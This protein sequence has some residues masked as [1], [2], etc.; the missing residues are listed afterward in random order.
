MQTKE[1]YSICPTA[2]ALAFIVCIMI[3][4]YSSAPGEAAEKAR[5][6]TKKKAG[7]IA[8]GPF[9][10]DPILIS[11]DRMEG[12]LKK[13]T[14]TYQGRVVVI[15]GEMTMKSRVL[16]GYY[17]SELNEIKKVVANGK[18]HVTQE[19]R[20]ATGAKAVFDVKAQTITLTGNPVLREGR[21]QI[22]GSRFI[23]FVDQNRFKVEGPVKSTLIPDELMEQKK[24]KKELGK[25]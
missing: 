4:V 18:V 22:S 3:A 8:T 1:N 11:S 15:Q 21:S 6:G 24:K 12:D 9:K 2:K 20:V 13:S 10:K 17:D 16:T 7:Q 19:G 25:K 23:F 5:K 14:V